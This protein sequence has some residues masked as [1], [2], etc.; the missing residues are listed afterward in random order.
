[1]NNMNCSKLRA[2]CCIGCQIFF[3]LLV[4]FANFSRGLWHGHEIWIYITQY[5]QQKKIQTQ[6]SNWSKGVIFKPTHNPFQLNIRNSGSFL[7]I[8]IGH[9]KFSDI[10]NPNT[11][12]SI[13]WFKITKKKIG[14]RNPT[15]IGLNIFCTH[16]Y[17]NLF[18]ALV[19]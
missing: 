1:M 2:A 16:L 14:L 5:N 18:N 7:V 10:P 19:Y 11:H 3:Y 12:L 9:L 8:S 13:S 17:T 6:Q 15:I 4:F